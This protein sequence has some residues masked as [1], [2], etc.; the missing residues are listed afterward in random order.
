ME[1]SGRPLLDTKPDQALFAGRDAELDRLL[2]RVERGL[3]VLLLGERGSGKTTLLRSLAYELRQK[4]PDTSPAFV[5]GPLAEDVRTF[6]YLVRHRLGLSTATGPT[7]MEALLSS[8]SLTRRTNALGDTLALPNLVAGLREAAPNDGRRVV[9]V[10]ELP[11]EAVAQTLFGRLR[12]ELWQLPLTW[13]VAVR[14]SA[15]GVL[16]QPPADAFF[17]VVMRLEPLSKDAQRAILGAR[18]G[19]QGQRLASKVDEGNPRRLLALAR[20][21]LEGGADPSELVGALAR[22]DAEVSKL[23]RP[24]SMLMAEL[25]S[26]GPSSASDERL[27]SRLGWTRSRAVQ[28]L[29]E[30]ED[31]G[32]VTSSTVKGESGRPRKVYRPADEVGQ[33]RGAGG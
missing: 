21:A 15:A 31:K 20:E 19:V 22:R 32:L 4:S 16:Q 24:A 10:D 23:G 12:D 27:L 25:E 33:R 28:V 14:P 8:A 30:L 18:G 17:D 2:T 9:L 26:L 29:R 13:V 3:N 7:P 1:L 11:S 5:E 6:I